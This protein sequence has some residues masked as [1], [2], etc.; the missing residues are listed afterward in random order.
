MKPEALIPP[1]DL[2]DYAK[3]R[4]WV[5]VKEAAKDR[6][7]VMN[8]PRFD[9]R[10]LVFPMDTTAPDYAEA[11]ML[12]LEKLAD[13]EGRRTDEVV[14]NVLEAGDD[15]IAFRVTTPRLD[16]GFV[17]LAYA[18]SML[19]GAQQMLL[20]SACTVLKPQIHHP[21]LSRSEAQ[22]FLDVA[23]F[24]HTQPGS[25]IL[26][27]SCPVRAMDIQPE[28]LPDEIDAPFV[29]RTTAALQRGLRQLV[30]A[31]ETDSL[32]DLIDA[33]KKAASPLVSSNLCEALTRFED[34]GLKT[35]VEIGITWASSIP[36]PANEGQVSMVRVQHDYFP[37]IEEVRCELRA[38][39]KHL[40]EVFPGTVERLE[41]EMG[42]DG[43]RSGEVILSL[44]TSDGEQLRARASL[45]ADQYAQADK[46]HMT[47][48]AFV[49]V[50]GKLHPGRQ[51]RLL[52]DIQFFELLVR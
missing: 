40:E 37:R 12:V 28:L 18:G 31:I 2:R 7:C 47:D 4:G 17:P 34:S 6:L 1:T 49:K 24:R 14:K 45:S 20:A 15:A 23:K 9:R 5:L 13:I 26:N 35:S 27:V 19:A 52:S 22:Q 38:T 43:R 44:L 10:Q 33:A 41:G 42:P 51:P 48:G 21:R 11:V 29:R 50:K 30:D 3:E 32:D 36:R 46:A 39:P 8:H 25:F 16:D